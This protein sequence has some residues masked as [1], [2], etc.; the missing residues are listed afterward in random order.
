MT[1]EGQLYTTILTTTTDNTAVGIVT[2]TTTNTTTTT[3]EDW[4]VADCIVRQFRVLTSH[5]SVL[6]CPFI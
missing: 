2:S 4:K 3:T 5:G 1:V 6:R